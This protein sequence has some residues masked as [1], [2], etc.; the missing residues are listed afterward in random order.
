MYRYGKS[1]RYA[2]LYR[3]VVPVFCTG[4]P[5]CCWSQPCRNL[6]F[7]S[8]PI[9]FSRPPPPTPPFMLQSGLAWKKPDRPEWSRN[10]RQWVSWHTDYCFFLLIVLTSNTPKYCRR[11]TFFN[12]W[13]HSL[14]LPSVHFKWKKRTDPKNNNNNKQYKKKEK[15]D[16]YKPNISTPWSVQLWNKVNWKKKKRKKRDVYKP[17]IS[18]LWSVQ[19]WNKLKWNWC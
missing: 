13:R 6:P 18:T 19:F 9:S 7:T 11:R 12:L 2:Y 10:R 3:I 16:N 17:N 15:K 8:S 1:Y 4:I 5:C 14:P